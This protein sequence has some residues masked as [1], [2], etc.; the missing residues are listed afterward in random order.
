MNSFVSNQAVLYLAKEEFRVNVNHSLAEECIYTAIEHQ[1]FY[2]VY[3]L[4]RVTAI[5]C[6]VY[7][8]ESLRVK[9]YEFKDFFR[10]IKITACN[11]KN[12]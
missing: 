5:E 1:N 8:Y 11:T 4:F 9:K 7:S 12:Q 2:L 6:G 3:G 10:P